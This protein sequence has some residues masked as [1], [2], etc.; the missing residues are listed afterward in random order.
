M[1]TEIVSRNDGSLFRYQ[2]WPTVCRDGGRIFVACSGHRLDHICPFGKDLIYHSDDNGKTWSAP[3]VANDTP[4]DDRDAG[5]VPLGG[6]RMLLTW[7]NHP[8]AFYLARR[9]KL[10]ADAY[11]GA[12]HL[13]DAML[14]VWERMPD[15]LDRPG[16]FIRLSADRGET[17]GPAIQVPVT[18]PHG[19]VPLSDGRLL[20]LG[21]EFFSGTYETGAIYAFESRDGG[22][23]WQMLAKLDTPE[24]FGTPDLHEPYAVELPGGRIMGVIRV[25]HKYKDGR[26]VFSVAKCFSDD[27]GRTWTRP[28]MTGVNGSPAHLLVHSSGAVV[29]VY[30]RRERPFGERARVSCDG[31]VTFGEEI[32]IGN[33]AESSDLGYP[34]SV[35]LDDGRIMTVYYQKLPGDRFASILYSIWSIRENGG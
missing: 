18:S 8:R 2:A 28:E 25:Q 32:V 14:D 19:P 23:S 26:G 5:L 1:I 20:Y 7:F 12:Q 9:G 10:G 27:G 29:M 16:S 15:E 22:E 35:E 21:K 33:E 3:L 31:G 30:G 34:S 24:G 6:G 11:G 13:T 4:L 17:W